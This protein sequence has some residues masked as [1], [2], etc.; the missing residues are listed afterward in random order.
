MNRKKAK[1]N[2]V[3][4]AIAV[5]C[6]YCGSP[7]KALSDGDSVWTL[8]DVKRDCLKYIACSACG[9]EFM[10][11]TKLIDVLFMTSSAPVS[12]SAAPVVTD[13]E[14]ICGD[15]S[16]DGHEPRRTLL[17][18]DNRCSACGGQNYTLAAKL[19][20]TGADAGQPQQPTN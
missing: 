2:V 16:G 7:A 12:E 10:L 1:F 13:T 9:E 20:P 4:I 18:K 3:D 8:A 19:Q 17:T 11:P 5:L 6:P 15:C 14:I